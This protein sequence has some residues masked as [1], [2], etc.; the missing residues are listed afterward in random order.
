MKR[1]ILIVTVILSNITLFSCTTSDLAD[2][3]SVEELA[4]EG[5]DEEILPEEDDND[6]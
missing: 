3:I 6:N 1:V 4:T 5:E 2:E